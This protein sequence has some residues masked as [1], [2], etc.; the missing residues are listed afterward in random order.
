MLL[1]HE[2]EHVRQWR[3]Y[4]VVGFPAR[5][6]GSYLRWRSRGYPH[7]AAYRRIPA[8]IEAEWQARRRL[9]VGTRLVVA[10][11]SRD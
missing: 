1:V 10:R 7:W 3:E 2:L 11:E 9:E 5:Y 4:G 6:V 8:E